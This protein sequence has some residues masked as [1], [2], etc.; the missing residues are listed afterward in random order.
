MNFMTEHIRRFLESPQQQ[1]QQ[2]FEDLFGSGNYRER[3][4]GL[5]QQERE[6]EAVALYSE[7][8]RRVGT[9]RYVS[10]AV[11]LHPETDRKYFHLIYATRNLKGIEVFKQA[12]KSAMAVMEQARATA[13]TASERPGKWSLQCPVCVALWANTTRVFVAVT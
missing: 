4:A 1:T 8:V 13:Q 9:F 7:N 6:D 11:V 2:S 3:L 12:E 5:S 10:A